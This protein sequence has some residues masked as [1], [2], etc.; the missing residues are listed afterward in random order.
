MADVT[1]TLA[2]L[3]ALGGIA[4]FTADTAGAI[5]T[6]GSDVSLTTGTRHSIVFPGGYETVGASAQVEQHLDTYFGAN[7]VQSGG[8]DFGPIWVTA[9]GNTQ[10]IGGNHRP[11]WWK[12]AAGDLTAAEIGKVWANSTNRITLLDVTGGYAYFSTIHNEAVTVL[13]YSTPSGTWTCSGKPDVTF[14]SPASESTSFY[15]NRVLSDTGI[16]WEDGPVTGVL[17]RRYVQDTTSF[18]RYILAQQSS[19]GTK[20]AVED[21]ESVA[22]YVTEW[23]WYGDQPAVTL[24]D[25]TYT[26]AVTHDVVQFSGLQMG[27][28]GVA[29]AVL[30]MNPGT[31]LVTWNATPADT[32]LEDE[33][34]ADA[35]FP[36]AFF[37]RNAY[38]GGALGIL[39]ASQTLNDAPNAG[40]A[41][42]KLYPSV[43]GR[44][45]SGGDVTLTAGQSLTCRGWRSYSGDAHDRHFHIVTDPV[46][47]ITHW[48]LMAG[49]T[50]TAT[51][52]AIPRWAGSRLV[53]T[54]GTAVVDGFVGETT[55]TV[56]AA[57]W[58][59]GAIA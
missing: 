29:N 12:V 55:V 56:T 17:L 44:T 22:T 1:P 36:P 28:G 8:D 38:G 46:T 51:H 43:I 48:F 58:A 5:A 20:I 42:G 31:D 23:R 21:A 49:S 39:A 7:A 45:G 6:A 13:S 57:G 11:T 34:W 3:A 53:T 4:Q 26:A 27:A 33:D 10:I 19:V 40:Q 37:T 50:G 18:G 54:R 30:G 52:P 15:L 9:D 32:L 47:G 24:V 41:S 59:E 16:M 35:I 25:M 14:S 2:T